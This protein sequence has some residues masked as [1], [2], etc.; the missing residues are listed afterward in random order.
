MSVTQGPWEKAEDERF[1]SACADASLCGDLHRYVKVL[2]DRLK[3]LDSRAKATN[4]RILTL[5]EGLREAREALGRPVSDLP[6]EPGRRVTALV[7]QDLV[8]HAVDEVWVTVG[9]PRT[10]AWKERPEP[11]ETPQKPPKNP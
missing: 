6:K 3:L 7:E 8:F 4:R 9:N 10:V 11:P 1:L 5:E 2:V